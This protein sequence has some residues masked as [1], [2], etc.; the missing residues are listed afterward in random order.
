MPQKHNWKVVQV[1]KRVSGESI[2]EEECLQC[3]AKRHITFPHVITFK[4]FPKR[5]TRF[6]ER[7]Q[8]RGYEHVSA[9]MELCVFHFTAR[10][11]P[12]VGQVTLVQLTI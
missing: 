8:Q 5:I 11:T 9:R 7:T 12:P 10:P 3:Y 6:C 1:K 2:E 4:T